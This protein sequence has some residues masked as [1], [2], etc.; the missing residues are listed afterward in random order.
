MRVWLALA[1]RAARNFE[2][3]DGFVLASHIAL[4]GLTA[5]FPFLIFVTSL[6]GLLGVQRL[7]DQAASAFFEIWPPQVAQPIQHE[8]HAV[9]SNSHSGLLTVSGLLALYF[10]SSGV[11]ALRIGLNRA[12][13][14]P[15]TRPWWRLRLQSSAYVFVGGAAL[16]ALTFLLVLGPT[17]WRT[18]LHYAP[19]LII[20]A[21]KVTIARYAIATI[22]LTA[23]LILAH[24][25]LPN[26]QLN[27]RHVWPG[28]VL[29]FVAWM[30]FALA[31]SSYLARFARN[32][33]ATYA[34]LASVMIAIM[35]LYSLGAIFIFGA[36][37]NAALDG[38]R[39]KIRASEIEPDLPL[40][41]SAPA[42]F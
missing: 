40:Q 17:L 20:F 42:R 4:S 8:I 27:L 31:F 16:L 14:A 10:A 38:R 35:F 7:A 1:R 12:Y 29:T 2:S 34:G 19:A 13:R 39:N 9:L 32:Y 23:A 37:W 25:M 6:A 26:R 33:V 11:E 3:D 28:I 18:A 24:M 21:N 5:I 22:I 41:N 36:E 15:E 30:S